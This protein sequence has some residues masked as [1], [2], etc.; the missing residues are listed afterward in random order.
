MH[1]AGIV[2]KV[3]ADIGLTL[4]I[5]RLRAQIAKL[6][7]PPSE[8]DIKSV[9]EAIHA[10]TSDGRE[11]TRYNQAYERKVIKFAKAAIT[12]LLEMRSV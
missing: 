10:S 12:K 8:G 9:A 4:E 5:E 1:E 7:A 3:V 2:T 6:T 11:L